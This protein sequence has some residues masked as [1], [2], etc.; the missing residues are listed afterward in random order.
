MRGEGG[1]YRNK[2]EQFEGIIEE[3]YVSIL[4][5]SRSG[6]QWELV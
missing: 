5:F 1:E 2:E 4:R 3:E 6:N